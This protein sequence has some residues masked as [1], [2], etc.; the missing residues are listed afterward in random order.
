MDIKTQD[1]ILLRNIPDGTPDDVIKARIQQIRGGQQ[2]Q[3]QQNGNFQGSSLGG[4]IQG[5]R[6]P[7]DAGAQM[8]AHAVPDNIEQSVNRAN[9]WLADKT[10]LVGK[11]PEQS[12]SNLVLGNKTGIDAKIANDEKSYQQARASSG[13]SGI[14]AARITGNV[15][16]TAPLMMIPGGQSV[17]AQV[18]SGATVGALSGALQPVT[19][20]DFGE[21]KLKQVGVGSGLGGLFGLGGAALGKVISPNVKP[22]VQALLH[23]DV[24]LTPG[25]IMGGTA[26]KIEDKAQS[27]PLLGDMITKARG[28]GVEDLNRAAYARA[29]KGTGVDAKALPVGQ[30]GITAIKDALTKQYDEL[31]P[32]LSF[33]PDQQ[34]A[35]ELSTV[36]SMAQNLGQKEASKYNSI[37]KDALS[38]TSPN[39]SMTGETYKIVESKLNNEAKKF[40][41]S[42]DAYQK[43]LGDALK[44]TLNI[45]KTN[46]ERPNPKYAKDFAQVNE[47]Y[48]NYARLRAAGSKAGDMSGGFSPAQL[49]AA[50]RGSDKSVGKGNVAMGKALMQDLSDAGVNVMGSKVSDSGTAGRLMLGGAAGGAAFVEPSLLLGAGATSLPYTKTGQ[51]IAEALLTK[52]PSGSKA[53]AEALRKALPLMSGSMIPSTQ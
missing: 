40:A 28:R 36:Q 8:L 7:I 43:E 51:K 32:K 53:A 17:G 10:G 44:E 20:G 19:E 15:A 21:E 14:D 13:R 2:P 6:D 39:G 25:Q 37:L 48:A 1:G 16:S 46:I 26:Q 42:S 24:R 31:L 33:N 23:Q 5:I 35:Q 45:F 22:E 12:L 34:F 52:R 50:I 18:A 41:S 30:E 47:N 49:A 3:S 38:K 27:I 29:L 4:I 11:L 9:N